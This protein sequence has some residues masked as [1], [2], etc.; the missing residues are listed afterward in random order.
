MISFNEVSILHQLIQNNNTITMMLSQPVPQNLSPEL[1]FSTLLKIGSIISDA[2]I[3]LDSLKLTIT[4][5]IINLSVS[6]QKFQLS[7]FFLSIK[8][9]LT[10]HDSISSHFFVLHQFSS[11]YLVIFSCAYM[12]CFTT[13]EAM[14]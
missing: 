1:F 14:L 4:S 7:I 10:Y 11:W 8:F 2:G 9:K 13:L 12:A 5:F 6:I 3:T